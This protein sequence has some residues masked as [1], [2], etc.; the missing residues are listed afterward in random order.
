MFV[1]QMFTKVCPAKNHLVAHYLS[2]GEAINWFVA[3]K[4]LFIS[5]LRKLKEKKCLRQLKI[6]ARAN[7]VA[8]NTK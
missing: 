2:P 1:V 6:M 7:V 4:Y 3:I 5:K 8:S